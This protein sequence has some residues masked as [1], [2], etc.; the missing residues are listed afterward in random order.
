M[1]V[2]TLVQI[3][4]VVLLLFLEHCTLPIQER[5]QHLFFEDLINLTVQEHA[6]ICGRGLVLC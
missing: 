6:I 1:T 2:K 3:T 4:A 5:Y